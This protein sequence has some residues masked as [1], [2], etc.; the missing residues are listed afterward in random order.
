MIA[1]VLV[2]TS[3]FES[4][5]YFLSSLFLGFTVAAIPF[6]AHQE[7]LTIRG[8]L[9]CLPFSF[10]GLIL[11]VLLAML[12]QTGIGIGTV[13]FLD[14]TVL[15]YGYL[16]AAGVLAIS[17]MLL[18]GISGSTLLLIFGVYVPA[19][20]ALREVLHLHLE[21]LPGVL[22]LATGILF[23][24]FFAAG[25]IRKALRR[26]RAQMVYLILGLMAGSLYAIAMGPTT[27]ESPRAP[28]DLS[29]FDVAAFLL[30][31]AIFSG[32]EFIKY[33]IENSATKKDELIPKA[34]NR[35]GR[36]SK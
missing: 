32:L 1:C 8:K 10:L 34:E 35:I 23:G 31:I 2:L 20:T 16:I 29:S 14:L 33:R 28:V 22:A 6:I 15:Q 17:A 24:I 36:P 25:L 12:R 5:I 4:S 9:C 26:F 21:Y 19:V 30:G 7:R 3:A 13:N 27:L 11:V 18:P